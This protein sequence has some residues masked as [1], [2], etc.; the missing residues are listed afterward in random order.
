MFRILYPNSQTKAVVDKKMQK[1]G[2]RNINDLHTQC[3]PKSDRPPT[4]TFLYLLPFPGL[5]SRIIKLWPA[6]RGFW[7]REKATK[8]ES[9]GSTRSESL[10][11]A[12]NVRQDAYLWT[13]VPVL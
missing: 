3:R 12:A 11:E 7:G 4:Y 2:Q 9:A 1:Q 10:E 5:L 6:A 8:G 13:L